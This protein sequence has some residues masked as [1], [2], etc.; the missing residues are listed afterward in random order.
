MKTTQAKALV[1]LLVASIG[2]GITAAMTLYPDAR[3][4]AIVLA[5]LTPVATYLGV[6]WTPNK[7][8]S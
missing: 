8:T 4:L 6:Y 3:E 1:G 7:P 5:V 2:S